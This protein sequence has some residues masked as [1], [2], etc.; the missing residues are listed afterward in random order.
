MVARIGRGAHLDTAVA[1]FRVHVGRPLPGGDHDVGTQLVGAQPHTLGAE[2]A[3]GAQVTFGQLVLAHHGALGLVQ[4]GLVVGHLH[5]EDV[6]RPEQAVGVLFQAEDAGAAIGRV[7]GAHALEYTQAVV[8]G[9]GED[10]DFRLTP[11]HQFAIHPDDPIAVC[12]IGCCTHVQSCCSVNPDGAGN[13]RCHT[14]S[15]LARCSRYRS[16][17]TRPGN[18]CKASW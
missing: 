7:V 9:V 10:M 3:H 11:W 2:E 4:R 16:P 8:K 15:T 5:A 6:G 12:K 17:S 18:C 1:G 13:R 14:A